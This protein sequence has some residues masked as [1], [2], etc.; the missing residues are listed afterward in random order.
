MELK[1]A[2]H[3]KSTPTKVRGKPLRRRAGKPL[4]NPPNPVKSKMTAAQFER[5]IQQQIRFW[6]IRI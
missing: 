5:L 3:M 6:G 4:E 2:P 1:G